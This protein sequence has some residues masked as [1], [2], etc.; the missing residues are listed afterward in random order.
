[1]ALGVLAFGSVTASIVVDCRLQA[2][3]PADQSYCTGVI[4]G[5]G[6]NHITIDSNKTINGPFFGDG[7]M[8]NGGNDTII[9]NGV[10]LSDGGGTG[11][12]GDIEGDVATGNGGSDVIVNNGTVA[13]DIDGDS[14]LGNGG[15]DTIINNG[16]VGDDIDG[17]NA[18][19]NGGDDFIINNG[20]VNGDIE[21][22]DNTTAPGSRGGDDTIIVNGT[23]EGS[24]FGDFGVEIGGDD[25]IILQNGANGG[26]DKGLYLDGNDGNDTL[27]FNFALSDQTALDNLAS[28]IA[29]ANPSD[30]SL[31][32]NGQTFTWANFEH[33][34]SQLTLTGISSMSTISV[35]QQIQTF[36]YGAGDTQAAIYCA[37]GSTHVV[38]S[39]AQ[40]RSEFLFTLKAEKLIRAVKQATVNKTGVELGNA[41]GQSLWVLPSGDLQLHDDAERYDFT[42]TEYSCGG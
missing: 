9:N 34:K 7:V 33:L 13:G 15:S 14:A 11:K 1:M 39:D 40:G 10:T 27:I 41:D 16:T 30:D 8:G 25:A 4:G 26:S 20:T 31:S 5:V 3:K 36:I 23:V 42:V 22:D 18:Q 19:N 28:Q 35:H 21:A 2:G 24:V 37:T 29:D 38:G 32:Y 12:N 17:D 6:N